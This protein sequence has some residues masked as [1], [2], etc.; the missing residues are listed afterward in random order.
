MSQWQRPGRRLRQGA[1]M[2]LIAIVVMGC[3]AIPT[4][5][6]VQ[7]GNADVLPVEPLQ[8]IPEGPNPTDDPARIVTGFLNASAG[9]LASDFAVAREFLT[10]ETAATWDPRAQTLVYR[11]G[12]LT[13]DWNERQGTVS[14]ELPLASTIDDSGR[15]SD[16][17]SDAVQVLSWTVVQ[18]EQGRWRSSEL[19]DGVVVSQAN[20]TRFFRAVDLAF[21][22]SDRT[23]I[24]PEVRWLP[25]N[26]VVTSAA[27]E[28]VQGPSGWLAD[29]VVTGFPGT[30][31]LAVESVV[32]NEGLATVDLTPQSAGT[33]EDRALAAEQMHIT[34]KSLPT[35]ADV[36]VR[37]GGLPMVT[38]NAITLEPAPVPDERAVVIAEE[39]LGV[40][41]GEQLRVTADS[42]GGV[43]ALAQGL[44][45]SYDGSR[46]AYLDRGS[47]MVT[48][49][50]AEPDAEFVQPHRN[51]EPPTESLAATQ[52][53][54][55]RSLVAPSFDRL[56]YLWTVESATEDGP[57]AVTPDGE[58]LTFTSEWLRARS[59]VAIAVS[60]DGSLMAVLSR[61]GGQPVVEVANIH[62]DEQGV[63]L[64][65][66]EPLPIG[67]GVDAGIDIAWADDS[68]VAVLG[69]PIDGASSPLWLITIGGG[70]S[71]MATQ[72]QA[73]AI[74]VRTG[75]ASLVVVTEEGR[76]D[77]RSGPTWAQVLTGVSELAFAG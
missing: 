22:T 71:V 3:A 43:G 65:L 64:G 73:V 62:R 16:S 8:P 70:T 44:A 49:A 57:L 14:Y 7:E 56:G 9:G 35:V 12:A 13:P 50:L 60:R 72:P 37:I 27:R 38:T 31:A 5:G 6:D 15:R 29:A 10:E 45:R 34:L 51:L 75:E 41:D 55:G 21:A 54:A 1:L 20:F 52:A 36:E 25:D 23:T 19:G 68:T 11:A 30:A 28:L 39:R 69:E 26:N 59:T 58:V 4:S 2:T 18:N 66:G 74:A 61:S 77:E 33:P 46:I 63:P 42:M 47:L 76:V 53:I 24:V 67:T 32:V 40:W 48:T 17:A